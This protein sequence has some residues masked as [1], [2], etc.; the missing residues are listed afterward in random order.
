MF[1]VAHARGTLD[2]LT[3]DGRPQV[4][5]AEAARKMQLRVRDWSVSVA[6]VED[7]LTTT[8]VPLGV[9]GVLARLCVIACATALPP[10]VHFS[11]APLLQRAET[12]AVRLRSL[13]RQHDRVLL[14]FYESDGNAWCLVRVERGASEGALKCTVQHWF[15]QKKQALEVLAKRLAACWEVPVQAV[16][17]QPFTFQEPLSHMLPLYL[18][19]RECSAGTSDRPSAAEDLDTCFKRMHSAVRS[20]LRACL[21]ALLQHDEP[22][23]EALARVCPEVQQHV[24]SACGLNTALG[25]CSAPPDPRTPLP[26]PPRASGAVASPVPSPAPVSP[27][28]PEIDK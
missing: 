15:K 16:R 17:F 8:R 1:A 14:P 13:V 7:F 25:A 10:N 6:E 22:D 27:S 23:L 4:D 11:Y 18:F 28:P 20:S 21:D 2:S 24:S 12:H 9:F 26:K 19:L 5:P 3:L